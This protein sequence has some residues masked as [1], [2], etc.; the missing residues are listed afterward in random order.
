MLF[1]GGF[2]LGFLCLLHPPLG[3]GLYPP[4]AHSPLTTLWETVKAEEEARD[5]FVCICYVWGEG[6]NSKGAEPGDVE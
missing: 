4:E 6:S 3:Q 2:Y 5:T 1:F